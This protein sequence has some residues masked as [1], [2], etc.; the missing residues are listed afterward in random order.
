MSTEVRII[1]RVFIYSSRQLNDLSRDLSLSSDWS[2]LLVLRLTQ[3]FVY[4]IWLLFVDAWRDLFLLF[5]RSGFYSLTRGETY[6]FCSTHE[7]MWE[8]LCLFWH[9]TLVS[10]STDDIVCKTVCRE[11]C[12]KRGGSTRE[13]TIS[14]TQSEVHKN[15]D[16]EEFFSCGFSACCGCYDNSSFELMFF[17]FICVF[18]RTSWIRSTWKSRVARWYTSVDLQIF[19]LLCN[20]MREWQGSY[21]VSVQDYHTLMSSI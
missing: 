18:Q 12:G 15:G 1:C 19:Q 9:Q 5:D 14:L 17:L 11:K 4:Q 6:S 21:I 13:L 16:V 8:G 20:R 2:V 3:R 7:Y 10:C